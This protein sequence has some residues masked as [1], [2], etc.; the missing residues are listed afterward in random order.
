M[1]PY[2]EIIFINSLRSIEHISYLNKI[3]LDLVRII[4]VR[5]LLIIEKLCYL[6][7]R[8]YIFLSFS[9]INY[10]ANT[11]FLN[12]ALKLLFLREEGCRKLCEIYFY[13]PVSPQTRVCWLLT[14]YSNRVYHEQFH[15]N[16]LNTIFWALWWP[17]WPRNEN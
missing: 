13:I 5:K 8:W 16:F 17:V 10:F 15:Y 7:N 1:N 4:I 9:Y 6:E 3:V 14:V 2:R 11:K 12:S